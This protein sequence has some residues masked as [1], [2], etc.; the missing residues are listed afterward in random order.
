MHD[1]MDSAF[2]GKSGGCQ[3]YSFHAHD[4]KFFFGDLNY[5]IDLSY[6]F[7]KECAEKFDKGSELQLKERDQLMPILA[8]GKDFP[9]LEE[10]YINFRPTYKYNHRSE[11]YDTSKKLRAPAWC[12]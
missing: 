6:E 8:E 3:K 1:I 9:M 2:K 10:P 4:I 5:R 11:E 12:D 7:A